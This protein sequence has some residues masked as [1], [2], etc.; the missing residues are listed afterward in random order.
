EPERASAD[1]ARAFAQAADFEGPLVD[2]RSKGHRVEYLG[3]E[4]I[5]GTQAHKLR[6]TR[7]DGDIEYWFLDPD[8]FLEIRIL[9]VQHVRGVERVSEIDVGN[10]E[11]VAGVWVP[12][13]FEAGD[14]GA[15]RTARITVERAEA[16]VTVDPAA[17][18]FPAP[19]AAMMRLVVP[20]SDTRPAASTPPPTAASEA[21]PV[22]DS[23]VISGLRARNIGS[24][25]MSGRISAIAARDENGST[26]VFVGAASG[27]VWKATDRGT[28]FKPGFDKNPVQSI[29]AIAFD[30]QNS[31]TIWVGTG[32]SWTRNSVSIGDGIY[33]STDGGQNWTN[34]GLGTSERIARILVHPKNGNVV[35]AC[36]PGK[37]W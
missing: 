8:A 25:A 34:L 3:T 29:G 7:K 5:D 4:E 31:K 21:Q 17:F 24:A 23:G 12:F 10:Y 37:L 22:V 19:G 18:R 35:Y 36:V 1:E 30:P 15:P 26:T 32:E 14:P 2:W 16:N 11:Q 20:G 33:R 9:R 28:T 6:I 13:S 27:G